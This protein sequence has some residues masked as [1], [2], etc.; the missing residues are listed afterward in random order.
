M[1]CF[2]AQLASLRE[3]STPAKPS[4]AMLWRGVTPPAR[5][6]APN[7]FDYLSGRATGGR[8]TSKHAPIDQLRGVLIIQATDHA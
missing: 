8:G 5:L 7:L 4:A 1:K 2:D 3:S 6:R